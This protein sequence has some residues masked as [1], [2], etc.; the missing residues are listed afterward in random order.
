[1]TR[2]SLEA[3][4]PPSVAQ[5]LVKD[6]SDSGHPSSESPAPKRQKTQDSRR[7]ASSGRRSSTKQSILTDGDKEK[8][9]E[10]LNKREE[11]PNT[12]AMFTV[13]TGPVPKTRKGKPYT[14]PKEQLS[15]GGKDHLAVAYSV[16]PATQW[17]QLNKYKKCCLPHPSRVRVEP[18]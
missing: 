6:G 13:V 15:L 3:K 14:G 11:D 2:L 12:T 9:R 1:M 4:S 8:L 5:T 10:W 16:S 7:R 18:C 17:N